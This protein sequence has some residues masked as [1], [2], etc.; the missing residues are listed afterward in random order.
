M[1]YVVQ[2]IVTRYNYIS[3]NRTYFRDRDEA[4]QDMH[5]MVNESV[6]E[7]WTSVS[8]FSLDPT[9]LVETWIDGWEGCKDEDD[10]DWGPI[11]E[12]ERRDFFGEDYEP[13][14]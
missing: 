7:D 9:T 5:R 3:S 11:S 4:H 10:E 6:G 14:M 8:L 1:I 2:M 12:E 13:G